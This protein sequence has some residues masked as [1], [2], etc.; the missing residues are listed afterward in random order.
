MTNVLTAGIAATANEQ[1]NKC[2][3]TVKVAEE[4]YIV[5]TCTLKKRHRG[6]HYDEIFSRGWV[7]AS[8]RRA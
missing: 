5:L 7:R 4:V 2:G 1:T 3:A 6:D 8:V